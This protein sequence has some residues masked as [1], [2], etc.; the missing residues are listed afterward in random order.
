[1]LSNKPT[2]AHYSYLRYGTHLHPTKQGVY[3]LYTAK[4][5]KTR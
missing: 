4:Q 3:E 1:M 5:Q 2:S